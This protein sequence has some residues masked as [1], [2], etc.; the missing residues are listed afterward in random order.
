MNHPAY[1]KLTRLKLFGTARAFAEE[2]ALDLGH[3]GFE[4]SFG[5]LVEHDV[6][7]RDGK[8]LAFAARYAAGHAVAEPRSVV[9]PPAVL[10]KFGCPE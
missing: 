8:A 2:R 3:L 6:S 4:E 1:D 7:E 10:T 9:G 5:L